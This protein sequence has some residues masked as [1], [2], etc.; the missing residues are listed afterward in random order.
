MEPG[1]TSYNHS[2]HAKY[3][4]D[5]RICFWAHNLGDEKIYAPDDRRWSRYHDALPVRKFNRFRPE[6]RRFTLQAQLFDRAKDLCQSIS[7]DVLA[8]LKGFDLIIDYFH[9]RNNLSIVSF[10][11][12]D[13]FAVLATKRGT[14]KT[15]NNSQ[16]GFSA[17]VSRN[18]SH[19]T[20]IAIPD[21]IL[22]LMLLYKADVSDSQPV[23]ILYTAALFAS[24]RIHSK[25]YIDLN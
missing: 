17:R 16:S 5:T 2:S 10:V 11:F 12:A 13:F 19:A 7:D 3:S 4:W 18:S 20:I 15:Y 22:A 1:L 23:L 6:L 9:K 24:R 8:S 21:I 25:S 14:N